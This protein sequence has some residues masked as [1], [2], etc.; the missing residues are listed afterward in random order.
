MNNSKE[1]PD[2]ASGQAPYEIATSSNCALCKKECPS[3]DVGL[4][5]RRAGLRPTRQRVDLAR[6]L[7]ASGD[8]HITADMLHEEAVRQFLPVSLATV[9]NTLQQFTNSGLLRR[10]AT[11][12]H[13]TWFDTNVSDHHHMFC[14]EESSI[15]DVP[16]DYV[17]VERLPPVPEGMEIARVEVVIRLKR[18]A[19]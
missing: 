1:V 16:A 17:T 10:L 4:K 7:F 5:L 8:R 15:I 2:C 19:T 3:R 14:D 9:Y 11:D 13:R 12:G 6:L 18:R